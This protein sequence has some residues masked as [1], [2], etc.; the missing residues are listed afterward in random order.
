MITPSRLATGYQNLFERFNAPLMQK[1]RHESYGEDIGQHSWLTADELRGYITILNLKPSDRVLDFGCGPGG[2]LTFI[3]KE[4]GCNIVGMDLSVPAL[5]VAKERA[6]SL[7]VTSLIGI[8]QGDGN[9]PLAISGSF[10][11]I[12]LFDVILHLRDRHTVYKEL[13]SFL[14]PGGKLLIT[15]A[16]ILTGAVSND[17]IKLRS[18][19][20]YTQF[21]PP[22]Y[23]EAALEASGFKILSIIDKT[24]G[25]LE[26]ASG[27]I[28]ARNNYSDELIEF[29]GLEVFLEQQQYLQ[30]VLELSKRRAL[31]RMVYL[32]EVVK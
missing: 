6:E 31:S 12:V 22:G 23:N 20:G 1:I 15:D 25:V 7:G 8:K 3:A 29:E 19:N 2:P 16:G 14:K 10:D 32:A 11:A 30:V 27:R 24:A 9:A 18:V 28:L 21:V 5:Q 26:N 17:E 4:V 13:F